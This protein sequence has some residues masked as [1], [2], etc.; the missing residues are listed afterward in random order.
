MTRFRPGLLLFLLGLV[1]LSRHPG[2]AQEPAR[3]P[4]F[5]F[6]VSEDNS[7][8]YLRLYGAELGEAP[9]IERMAREGLT[10]EHAF[11]CGPVCS[12]A[13]STLAT[14]IYA[15]RAGFQYHRRSVPAGLPAGY[16]PW[17]AALRR[18]GYY[19]TNNSKTDY[20]FVH[21]LRELWDESSNRASWR[22]RPDPTTPF[23]HM[24]SW[25][26]SHESSLHFPAALVDREKTRTP[27]EKVSLAPYH[28][29]TPLF[30]YTH[31]RYFDRMRLID[32]QVGRVL[33]ELRADGLLED[34]FVFYF[35][36]HGG[37]LP[38]GKGYVYESGLHVPLVV[39]VPAHFRHL[40]P[41]APGA[42]L[43]GFVEFVDFGPTVLH[44]AGLPIPQLVDG[45]PFLGPGPAAD[46][47]RRDTSFGYADRMDEKFDHVRS[48]RR[49]RY[50]YV[51]NFTGFYPDGLQNNYRYRMAAC[52]EWREL[53]RAGRL[54]GA[55]SRFFRPRPPEQLFDVETDPHQ[56]RDLSGDPKRKGVLLELR[57]LMQRRLRAINDLSYLPESEVCRAALGDG[58]A[59]G[60]AYSGQLR[61]LARIA[62]FQ[63]LPYEK[64]R[65]GIRKAMASSDPWERYWACTAA[66]AHGGA[67]ADLAAAAALLLADAVPVVRVRAAEFL[68]GIRHCDPMPTL[69]DVLSSVTTEQEVMLAFQA[70]VYLRDHAGWSYDASRVKLR[71]TGGEVSRRVDYLAGGGA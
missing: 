16:L 52:S 6:L 1:A 22:G 36:D 44:L 54:D 69:Y 11:S 67:A 71:F 35:G 40:A 14:G 34:T 39:R 12:V 62:D 37:V 43:R 23:F 49:G 48:L 70:V 56:V 60:R 17:S 61:R 41:H 9:N 50:A 15:P 7:I 3:R 25:P 29:D 18:A 27:P 26:L 31:A 46:L 63:F 28:P 2:E 21:S 59:F 68:G 53:Y 45:R 58:I 19:A 13:R 66:A 30:R 5:V 38:R 33:G 42:R 20:N 51:R 64:A 47:E 32:E 8:H 24:E 55:R 10:F 57:G 4:N 65:P